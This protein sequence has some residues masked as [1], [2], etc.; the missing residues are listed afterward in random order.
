MAL[1]YRDGKKDVRPYLERRWMELGVPAAMQAIR[2]RY[3][4]HVN[5]DMGKLRE[6]DPDLVARIEV[7]FKAVQVPAFLRVVS[8]LHHDKGMK[9]VGLSI[10]TGGNRWRLPDGREVATDIVTLAPLDAQLT[11]SNFQ[12]V[13]G[14]S[15]VGYPQTGPL[16]KIHGTNNDKKRPWAIPPRPERTARRP[17]G[18]THRYIGG[19]NDTGTCDRA[20]CKKTRFDPV[21]AVPEGLVPHEPW[22]G[23]DGKGPLCDL[24]HQDAGEDTPLHRGDSVERHAFEGPGAFCTR[25]G[26]PADNAAFHFAAPPVDLP[27][28]GGWAVEAAAI[29]K[30]LATSDARV[31]ELAAAVDALEQQLAG[32][33]GVPSTLQ[34]KTITLTVGP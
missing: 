29:R 27:P 26:E 23:E 7:E 6:H 25:C 8:E 3:N 31:T 11:I 34:V 9:D 10:K 32:G 22:L 30:A 14:S 21:H 16:W 1:K 18:D 2:D 4:V 15:A 20:G 19:G 12:V 24:C 33:G 13:D 17:P 5:D 28:A